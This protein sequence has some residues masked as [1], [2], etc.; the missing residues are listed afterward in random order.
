MVYWEYMGYHG[1]FLH[2]L[3]HIAIFE[4]AIG[5]LVR[6]LRQSLEDPSR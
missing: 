4:G 5:T 6:A 3:C 2:K 1:D